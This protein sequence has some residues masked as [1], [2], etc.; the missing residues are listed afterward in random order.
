MAAPVV[1]CR[2]Q[3]I[4]WIASAPDTAFKLRDKGKDTGKVFQDRL[5]NLNHAALT[6]DIAVELEQNGFTL[7]DISPDHI[8]GVCLAEPDFAYDALCNLSPAQGMQRDFFRSLHTPDCSLHGLLVFFLIKHC[9]PFPGNMPVQRVG[10]RKCRNFFAPMQEGQLERLLVAFGE[11]QVD[12][13]QWLHDG[14][15]H[16][17]VQ[18]IVH[19][20]SPIAKLCAIQA[21]SQFSVCDMRHSIFK[22]WGV[23]ASP[24]IWTHEQYPAARFPAPA[25]E[26]IIQPETASLFSEQLRRIFNGVRDEVA[27]DHGEQMVERMHVIAASMEQHVGGMHA[28]Y[29][30]EAA[31]LRAGQDTYNVFYLLHCFLLCNLLRSDK[32]LEEAVRHA[33]MIVL[34]RHVKDVVVKMLEDKRRPM[35]SASTVS[36][37]RLKVDVA[38]MLM[39]RKELAEKMEAGIVVHC[40]ADS[41]PQG[42]HDYELMH[43]TM[44]HRPVLP[45]LHVDIL[46]LERRAQLSNQDRL[47]TL[48]DEIE[49]MD[50][51][52]ACFQA[53]TPPAVMLGM[54]RHRSSLNLK[55][56]AAMHALYLMAGPSAQLARFVQS[57]CTWVS[58]LGTEAGFAHIHKTLFKTLMPYI[59]ESEAQMLPNW[60]E[61]VDLSL[62]HP[63][64][65]HAPVSIGCEN[66]VAVPGLLH[67]LHNAFLGLGGS[68]HHFSTIVEQIK[69]VANL[70]RQPESKERLL[71]TCFQD[72]V[73]QGLAPEIKSFSG[74]VYEERWGTVSDCVLKLIACEKA[75]RHQWCLD[76]YTNC[77]SNPGGATGQSKAGT[78]SES[79]NLD[80]ADTAISD[81][82][83]WGYVH[84]LSTFGAMQMR[85]ISWAEGC[86]CHW[87]LIEARPHDLPIELKHLCES[88]PMRGRR[89]CELAS[90]KFN[91]L[92]DELCR[93]SSASLV[94]NMPPTIAQAERSAILSD[95]ENGRSHI[96]FQM[97]L[98]LS[99]WQAF[100]WRAWGASC[101]DE[102]TA[103]K[104][105]EATLACDCGHRVV[106]SAQEDPVRGELLQFIANPPALFLNEDAT[107]LSHVR[108]WLAISRTVSVVER[109]IEGKHAAS[110]KE[111]KRAPHHGC[112]Y[113]SLLHRIGEIKAALKSMPL[114]IAEL[115]EGIQKSRSGHAAVKLLNLDLHPD[116]A[117]AQQCRDP[118]YTK[119]IYHADS[120]VKYRMPAPELNV[121]KPSFGKSLELPMG[122][123]QNELRQDLARRHVQAKLQGSRPGGFFSVPMSSNVFR[124]LKTLLVP[125]QGGIV[126][127]SALSC[128]QI[129]AGVDRLADFDEGDFVTDLEFGPGIPTSA[130]KL[131]FWKLQDNKNAALA[132]REKVAGERSLSGCLAVTVHTV[133]KVDA[134]KKEI[135]LSTS[136]MNLASSTADSVPLVFN[137]LQQD[138][139]QLESIRIWAPKD[140]QKLVFT[141]AA[142][143][144][145]NLSEE[146]RQEVPGLLSKLMDMPDG[147]L[148]GKPTSKM[149]KLLDQLFRDSLLQ[150]TEIESESGAC[151]RLL[152]LTPQGTLCV[153]TCSVVQGGELLCRAPSGDSQPLDMTTYE[154]ILDMEQNGFRHRE[155]SQSECR[156]K[157]KTPYKW[158]DPLEWVTR[159]NTSAVSHF[160]LVALLSAP[161]HGQ[162]VPHFQPDNVYKKLLGLPCPER[163][164]K[165]KSKAM[166]IVGESFCPEL[167][168]PEEEAAPKKTRQR[169]GGQRKQLEGED[170]VLELERDLKEDEQGQMGISD[171]DGE[172]FAS[173]EEAPNDP[174]SSSCSKSGKSASHGSSNRS[175]S[176]SSSTG[177]SS[178]SS[179]DD[180]SQSGQLQRQD[181]KVNEKEPLASHDSHGASA[182]AKM[183]VHEKG[184]GKMDGVAKGKA[185]SKSGFP[186]TRGKY[187]AEDWGVF[188]LIYFDRKGSTGYQLTCTN[189]KHNLPG[190][191]LCTKSRSN[192]FEGGSDICLRM[193]KQWALMGKD[194]ESKQEHNDLW[195]SVLN[196]FVDGKVWSEDELD[197]Q[198][199]CSWPEAAAASGPSAA[200]GIKKRKRDP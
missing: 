41:S 81:P 39:V 42:G 130:Q 106:V 120:W 5:C 142:H 99:H 139:A 104:I 132:R 153:E 133:L 110:A 128:G 115:A 97:A 27:R 129:D 15:Q 179:D 126:P 118:T 144:L 50:R 57:I 191:A 163:R 149:Q 167:L 10:L 8:L 194:V 169:R 46:A 117:H 61:E 70:M 76:K 64:G 45:Q 11:A 9:L 138:L 187:Q 147:I 31:V 151:M 150:E 74:H 7:Q 78:Q 94:M 91:T 174:S 49:L 71:R 95:F 90:G 36:R 162:P 181:V 44:V 79:V 109:R 48:G 197:T 73:G 157:K 68:M 188:K 107:H 53:F 62:D 6:P 93:V 37:L 111:V 195:P 140:D 176:S 200:S 92:L 183:S 168:V 178:S 199:V 137:P 189:P 125:R 159:E 16:G 47:E 3:R 152:Q 160:Y 43:V 59:A 25:I 12:V 119:I 1:P 75:L 13:P 124:T 136:P 170:D 17:A 66:S 161:D 58:D 155:L 131:C 105:A 196:S 28:T 116:A 156:A 185:Q 32:S 146:S 26:N 166:V 122:S 14:T 77:S 190:Q 108:E 141:F 69:H 80:M 193:L 88:C 56:H 180:E 54:G 60:D 123:P 29:G 82:F 20:P 4:L 173:C 22:G 2:D 135:T 184:D 186:R 154:L 172:E 112:P 165:N 198:K 182:K 121:D 127:E 89:A 30:S 18:F 84:M 143:Y 164:L 192:R 100:P 55:F 158:G 72:L 171:T 51:I 19:L 85:L 63:D 67:I 52:R 98:K 23:G 102:E 21:W 34:P 40:M 87:D 177:T 35:P 145:R 148:L 65:A 134:A 114:C 103:A 86:A 101:Q 175:S 96:L 24:T 38:W 33:C 83:F 113:V